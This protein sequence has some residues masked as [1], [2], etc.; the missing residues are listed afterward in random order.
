MQNEL[1]ESGVKIPSKEEVEK[2]KEVL[3]SKIFTDPFHTEFSD[4]PFIKEGAFNP[5]DILGCE[6][7]H[8]VEVLKNLTPSL[9]VQLHCEPFL[10]KDGPNEDSQP[11]FRN[12]V[13]FLNGV[14]EVDSLMKPY[15]ESGEP[16]RA[17]IKMRLATSGKFLHRNRF[18]RR[19]IIMCLSGEQTWLFLSSNGGGA[20]IYLNRA[21]NKNWCGFR[22]AQ[23]T[24]MLSVDEMKAI[25]ANVPEGTIAK[26][27]VFKAGDL[28]E[29]DGR[30]WHAT[31]YNTPVLNMFFTPGEDGEAAVKQHKERH[32]QPKHKK[33]KLC[34]ISM[35]K[36]AKL[37]STWEKDES[38]KQITYG[39]DEGFCTL[40]QHA[41]KEDAE[42]DD[43]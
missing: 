3:E 11:L 23:H 29:F 37:S 38:G 10:I 27:V 16:S 31:S 12:T 32:S 22:S 7:I 5:K 17:R 4:P 6:P 36:T 30:W 25:A 41:D 35:A 19:Q 33:F 21:A 2:M 40:K 18:K 8:F 20:D 26:L 1:T 24:A 39:E 42:D 28:M 43:C 13:N 14:Q 15:L 9:A 34:S